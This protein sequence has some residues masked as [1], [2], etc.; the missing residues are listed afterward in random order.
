MSLDFI[1]HVGSPKTGTSSLQF[2]LNKNASLL[3]LLGFYYPMHDY[4]PNGI[5]GG[6][7]LFAKSILD[8]DLSKSLEILSLYKKESKGKTVLLSSESLYGCY[9]NLSKVLSIYKVRIVI[10]TR[11]P[12]DY[13]VSNYCQVVKRH[14]FTDSF[15]VYVSNGNLL[16]NKGVTGE[17]LNG[18]I[19]Y[20]N[21]LSIYPYRSGN[22]I[23]LYCKEVL[24]SF[25]LKLLSHSARSVNK[26][27]SY[28]ALKI[29]IFLN[30]TSGINDGDLLHLERCIQKNTDLGCYSTYKPS[31]SKD[32]ESLLF[33]YDDN[34]KSLLSSNYKINKDYAFS[35][36]DDH[37][38]DNDQIIDIV[39]LVSDSVLDSLCGIYGIE[40]KRDILSGYFYENI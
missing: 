1:I 30:K 27:F 8:N 21:N 2:F 37:F 31:F 28:T 17:V 25:L 32:L 23:E 14:G 7:H 6:H 16:N 20:F 22:T 11:N 13:L 36:L 40:K 26:S 24:K 34:V 29:K 38:L 4:D 3:K 19:K 15:E 18:W 10:F 39:N 9:R 12:I 33:T 35:N 5:S